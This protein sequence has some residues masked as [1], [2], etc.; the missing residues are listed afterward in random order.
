[1]ARTTA[2]A[3]TALPE[4]AYVLT[5]DDL[6]P[7]DQER[8]LALLARLPAAVRAALPDRP[9]G[10]ED[11]PP[12]LRERY[13]APDGRARIEVFAS[14]DLTR[15]G[16]LARFADAVYRVRPDAAGAA[17]GTVEFARAIVDALRQALATAVA[18]IAVLLLLLWRSPR[19]VAITLAPLLLGSLLI[20]ALTVAIGLP[21]N[22]ANVIVLPLLLGI[23]VDS[24]IHLVH[25]HRLHLEG[26]RDILHTSTA[27]A[28]LFSALTTGV[29]FATL[30]FASHGGI[31]TLA[32]LLTSGIALMLATNLLLLP[33]LLTLARQED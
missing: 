23:G 26:D 19:D 15:P 6:L 32:L 3:L 21:F 30:A 24:G 4:V 13:L 31:S 14:E 12:A 7:A 33:A 28:V 18:A 16:A 17:V 1:M 5:V 22:F 20:A 25:R 2:Q 9:V 11:L 29:S 10:P 27:R 8:K